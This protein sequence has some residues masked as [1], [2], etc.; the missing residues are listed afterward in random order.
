MNEQDLV[1]EYKKARKNGDASR[2]AALETAAMKRL[3]DFLNDDNPADSDDSP[4]FFSFIHA[5]SETDNVDLKLNCKKAEAKLLPMLKEFDN[6]M[7]FDSKE[8]VSSEIL[9][10]NLND[11][12]AFERQDVSKNPMFGQIYKLMGKIEQIDDDGNPLD[13]ADLAETI[14]D[15][16]KLKTYLRLCLNLDKI[17]SEA[18]FE[19]LLEE[20]EKTL[21][22]LFVMDTAGSSFDENEVRAEFEKLLDAID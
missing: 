17:T 9:E 6:E 8:P 5:F 12:D 1:A 7:G 10:R 21:I 2:A 4:L 13:S 20:M 11:L 22:T 3:D 15:A 19:T 18:Y 14:T 16:G